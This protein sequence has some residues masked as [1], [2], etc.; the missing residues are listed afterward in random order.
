[1]NRGNLFADAREE[2]AQAPH[3]RRC[4]RFG[5]SAASAFPSYDGAARAVL[6]SWLSLKFMVQD[7]EE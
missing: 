5:I 1:M 7:E 6:E 2:V 4:G 3:L